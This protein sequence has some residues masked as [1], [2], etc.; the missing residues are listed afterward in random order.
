ML[1][2]RATPA[3]RCCAAS[4]RRHFAGLPPENSCG[5][6]KPEQEYWPDGTPKKFS[7]AESWKNWIDWDS[8]HR[9]L[10]D[11]LNRER[12]FFFEVDP[13]GHLFRLEIDPARPKIWRDSRWCVVW[14]TMQS[15]GVYFELVL[16]CCCC[17]C[18]CVFSLEEVNYVLVCILF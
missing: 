17:C 11:E 5:D 18:C 8:P 1:L 16:C 15:D 12:K 10:T 2:R 7:G 3:F 4:S 13:R 14:G 6:G 9:N